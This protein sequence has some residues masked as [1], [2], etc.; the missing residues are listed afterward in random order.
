MATRVWHCP[1]CHCEWDLSKSEDREWAILDMI[2][3][4]LGVH[5]DIHDQ[6]GDRK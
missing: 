6:N 4:A 1:Q 5:E 3:H 2:T